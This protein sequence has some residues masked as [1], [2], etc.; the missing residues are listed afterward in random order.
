MK[1]GRI[2][3]PLLLVMI[4][5]TL[6]CGKKGDTGPTG[7]IGPQGP[8][9]PT[10]VLGFASLNAVA[11]T[12]AVYN[13]GGGRTTGVTISKVSTGNFN[14]TFTGTYT[15]VTGTG[16]ITVLATISDTDVLVHVASAS[17]DQ[18][19]ANATTIVVRVFVLDIP[20]NVLADADFS[21]VV[22]SSK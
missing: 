2:A 12:P 5:G 22:L 19:S 7:P 3:F 10:E 8:P 11:A 20:G 14:V 13:F 9:G 21:V 18:G 4:F 16:D 6:G 15:G 17:M 1:I